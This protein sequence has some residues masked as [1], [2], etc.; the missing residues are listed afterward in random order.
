MNK[1]QSTNTYVIVQVVEDVDERKWSQMIPRALCI[2]LVVELK[3][4]KVLYIYCLM[5][6][7]LNFTYLTLPSECSERIKGHWSEQT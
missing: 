2:Y 1:L 6:N 4:V 7:F 5:F 3:Q